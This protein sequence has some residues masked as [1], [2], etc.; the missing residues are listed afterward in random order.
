VPYQTEVLENV[1]IGTTIYDK[2]L[3]TEKDIVTK[4]SLIDSNDSP[5]KF[6]S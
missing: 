2:I 3:I 6:Q 5:A 4:I 1:Q